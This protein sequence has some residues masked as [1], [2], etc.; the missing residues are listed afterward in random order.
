MLDG[1]NFDRLASVLFEGE[2]VA[3]DF[4]TMP[5]TDQA[6][7]RDWLAGSLLESMGRVGLLVDDKLV[8]KVD[9]KA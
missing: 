6:Q 9:A 3:V 4:K 5:G 1:S 2:V 8:N 7:S